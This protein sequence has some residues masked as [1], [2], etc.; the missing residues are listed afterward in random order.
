MSNW[1]KARKQ[2]IEIHFREVEGTYEVIRTLEGQLI[3]HRERDFIIRGVEGELY[4]IRKSVFAK[5][6]QVTE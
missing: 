2:P 4:P 1:K 5:T 6:Y 3:A